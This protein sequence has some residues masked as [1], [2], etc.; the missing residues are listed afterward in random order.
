MT[1]YRKGQTVFDLKTRD[2][3]KIAA[4]R[5]LRMWGVPRTFFR[6]EGAPGTRPEDSWRELPELTPAGSTTP[7]Y[8]SLLEG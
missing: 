6:L 7:T 5:Q 1:I 3:Y 8:R 4:I 2:Y